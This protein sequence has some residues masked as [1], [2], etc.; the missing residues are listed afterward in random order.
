MRVAPG[1][2][3]AAYRYYG[4]YAF[5]ITL[6]KGI[7]YLCLSGS[8]SIHG[9]DLSIDLFMDLSSQILGCQAGAGRLS[10]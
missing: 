2:G 3:V 1:S 4:C 7:L 5:G 10:L 8:R 6:E 9:L